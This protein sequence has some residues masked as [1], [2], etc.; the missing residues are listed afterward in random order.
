MSSVSLDKAN[1]WKGMFS[2]LNTEG[3]TTYASAAPGGSE[4]PI[5]RVVIPSEAK[6][7]E[8]PAFHESDIA[9]I[10]ETD[11]VGR[12]EE[13]NPVREK[14]KRALCMSASILS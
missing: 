7:S 6:P 4:R 3:A 13:E 8:L 10:H 14:W 9:D 2:S 12:I 5:R 11:Q 1:R